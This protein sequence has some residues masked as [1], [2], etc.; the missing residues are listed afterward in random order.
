[1]V[2]IGGEMGGMAGWMGGML[3]IRRDVVRNLVRDVV[4]IGGGIVGAMAGYLLARQGLGVTVLEGDSLGG[5]A[6]GFAF[7][8]LDPLNG[9]GLPEPL[10]DFSLYCFGRHWSMARELQGITGIDP[11]FRARNRL[12][13]AFDDADVLRYDADVA[14]MK[15]VSMFD[16]HWVGP[17]AALELEPKAN[18]EC[19]GALYQ[20][21]A[22]S[23]EAHR[24]T[25]A[26]ARAAERHGAHLTLERA[27]GLDCRGGRVEAV[28]CGE[29]RIAAGAVIAAMGPWSQVLGDWCGASV[30]VEPLKGQILR[31]RYDGAPF[32][33][34][35][36][37]RGNYVDSKAD[38]LVW[39][40]STEEY[41]GFN[42]APDL[43]GRD[44]VL[45]HIARMSPEVAR[46]ATVAQHTACLRPVTPDGIPAVGR[47]PGWD[48]LYIATG[49]GR[50]GILWSVGMSE[51]VADL[52]A[53]GDT[54]TPGA[55]H[56]SPARF[57]ADGG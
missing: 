39:A 50:K 2:G 5:H 31:L 11:G 7:G 10:L 4:V 41:A 28:I 21:G 49:A 17:E 54:Q 14:W 48:N 26:A 1:M 25:L 36:N 53:R 9:I 38:G 46:R 30:P 33:A 8:G 52:A 3:Y 22:A 47:L 57:A 12:Y 32:N 35:L 42:A 45:S 29:G 13:L 19:V 43:A 27:T 34:A 23:V 16:V 18:P 15:D 44:A 6:S 37:Y 40:G 56:L 24:L 51:M 20:Q 55:E